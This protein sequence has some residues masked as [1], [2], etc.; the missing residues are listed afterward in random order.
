MNQETVLITFGAGS[1]GWKDAAQRIRREA[2][3]CGLFAEVEIFDEKWIQHFEPNLWCQIQDY[4]NVN[5][6]RGFGY[7]M[8]KPAL[9]N[10]A[11]KK[12]PDKQILYV[13]SGFHIDEKEN[14][15]YNFRDFLRTAFEKG[16]VAFEQIGLKEECWTKREIFDYFKCNYSDKQKD[17]LYAGFILMAPGKTRSQFTQEFYGVTKFREGFL[18]NDERNQE[19]SM[20]FIDTRHDQSIFSILWRKYGLSTTPDLTTSSNIGN[21]LFIAARNRTGISA[22]KP[23]FLLRLV[24]LKNRIRD[25]MVDDD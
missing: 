7:W 4:F 10:W 5:Q 16:G 15:I 25:I 3:A 13:D 23:E 20:K 6:S 9:L 21:F 19:Q 24:R 18:F 22:T 12:W 11:D 8:W 1:S 14:L 2:I 17:Q